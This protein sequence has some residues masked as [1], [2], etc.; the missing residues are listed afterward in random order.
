MFGAGL[1]PT[2]TK[3]LTE[4]STHIPALLPLIQEQLLN[5]LSVVLAGKPYFH[6]GTPALLRGKV[7]TPVWLSF[8]DTPN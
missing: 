8:L 7:I 1:S 2:L 6:P 5:M 3:A 4:L